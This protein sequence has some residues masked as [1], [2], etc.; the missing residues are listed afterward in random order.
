MRAPQYFTYGFPLHGIYD[1]SARYS[2]PEGTAFDCLNVRP[3]DMNTG[4]ARGGQRPGL[5]KYSSA[6]VRGTTRI[7]DINYL[8]YA[9][10]ATT[11]GTAMAVRAIK[12]LAVA[13]GDI[14]V[15]TTTSSS[16]PAGGTGV[17]ALSATPAAIFSAPMFGVMFYVDGTVYKKYTPGTDTVAT[18]TASNGGTLPTNGGN[19]ARLIETW[20]GRIGL[21]GVQS[22]PQNWFMSEQF[23]PLD[24]NY[25]PTTPNEQQAV[26]GNN[27]PAGYVGDIINGVIPYN[28]DILFFLG[29]H[30][31]WQMTGDPASEGRIDNIS[32]VIGGAWGR[33]WCRTP[34]GTIYFLGNRGGIYRCV[35]DTKPE[36][37]TAGPINDRMQK[38]VGSTFIARMAYNDDEIG[39]YL[40]VT[41]LAGNAVTN[42]YYDI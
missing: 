25:A 9:S 24:Y 11:S 20:R 27:A 7:Q 35:P 37:I 26:A 14:R 4:R 39:I 21:S 32:D 42:Y 29:D 16:D 15:M 5:A 13:D 41:D 18:W 34:D 40:W 30:T 12:L 31:V 3:Y 6:Q 33:A 19:T 17:N 22:D 28:D 38:F 1:S 8:V 23:D 36:K 2:Q 10:T